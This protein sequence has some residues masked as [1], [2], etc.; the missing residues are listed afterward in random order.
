MKEFENTLEVVLK[1]ELQSNNN[2][3]KIQILT[4]LYLD[5]IFNY[6]A[7]N[8]YCGTSI[9]DIK[10]TRTYENTI[11]NIEKHFNT[12]FTFDVNVFDDERI[13]SEMI[14]DEYIDTDENVKNY[15]VLKGGKQILREYYDNEEFKN[16]YLYMKI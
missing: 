13:L 15:Y 10:H 4:I 9:N 6:S 3:K 5:M 11:Q 14:E 1:Q 16:L 7:F 2:I 8:K 12:K